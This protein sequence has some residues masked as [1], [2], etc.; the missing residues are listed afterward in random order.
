MAAAIKPQPEP[1][2]FGTLGDG[3]M[4]PIGPD[5]AAIYAMPDSTVQTALSPC[6]EGK[7]TP[8]QAREIAAAL[9]A[10]A[11]TAERIQSGT[12]VIE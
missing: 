8:D 3:F 9:L 4:W 10:A 1:I 5:S 6:D 12:K 7:Y 11:D 2:S